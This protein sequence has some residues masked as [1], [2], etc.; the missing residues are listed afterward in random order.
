MIE[1]VEKLRPELK[2][3]S[4]LD[5]SVLQDRAIHVLA[6]VSPQTRE[7][8]RE[9]ADIVPKLLVRVAVETRDIECA[10]H[11][12]RIPVQR[13]TQVDQ[14]P[15]P[16]PGRAADFIGVDSIHDPAADN[17]VEHRTGVAR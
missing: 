7:F 8:S 1:G 13:A 5:A 15:G 17:A 12:A 14:G 10:I 3:R 9:R 4:L 2:H 6:G 16:I 11:A